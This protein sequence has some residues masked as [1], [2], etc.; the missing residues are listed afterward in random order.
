MRRSVYFIL[1]ILLAASCKKD[2]LLTYNA[3]DNIYFDYKTGVD[4][5]NNQ[6]GVIIDSL[7]F[8]FA[9]S[10]ASLADSILPIPVTVSGTPKNVDRTYTVAIDAGATAVAGTHYELPTLKIRA[11]RVYDTLFL[12][13]KRAADLK[14]NTVRMTLRL[15]PDERFTTDIR[16]RMK[17]TTDTIR[18][19][20]FKLAIADML[21]AGPYWTSNYL[22]Y[23][24]TYSEKKVRLMNTITGMP[25]DFWVL[26]NAGSSASNAAAIYYA[27]TMGRYLKEQALNG[28]TI[29]E[30]DG[31]TPMKMA[32]EYQ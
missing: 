25:L 26:T 3:P 30:A 12:R 20:I 28:N 2:T 11:G 10:K 4:L 27:A 7:S 9:Y 32:T 8:T 17:N 21:T 29:Y 1:L 24:G 22:K 18:T 23:F 14:V 5:A 19:L 31:I 15:L 6:P 13:V 16:F